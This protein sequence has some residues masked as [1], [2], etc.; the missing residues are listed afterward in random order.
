MAQSDTQNRDTLGT[1]DLHQIVLIPDWPLNS[2]IETSVVWTASYKT[3]PL[4]P[5]EALACTG[6][7]RNAY[8]SD[9]VSPCSPK[10]VVK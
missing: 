10:L 9:Q 5:K 2:D 8:S 1:G 6:G 3:H 7:L 4:A